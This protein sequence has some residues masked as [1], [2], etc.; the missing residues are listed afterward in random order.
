MR[1]IRGARHAPN[2]FTS[3]LSGLLREPSS[4]SPGERP[5]GR[6]AGSEGTVAELPLKVRA[7]VCPE[8]G[9]PHDRDINAA[10][11]IL[12]AGPVAPAHGES[13]SPMSL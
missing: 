11:H 4:F 3:N 6:G 5:S 12:A 8:C 1:S 9:T 13:V 10:R 7:W 2:A